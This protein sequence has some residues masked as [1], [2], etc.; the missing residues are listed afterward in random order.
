ME[1]EFW[2]RRDILY[3][4]LPILGTLMIV[5]I[6]LGIIFCTNMLWPM[7]IVGALVLLFLVCEMFFDQRA[8]SKVVFS[9]EGIEERFLGKKVDFI[10]WLEITEVKATYKGKSG[11]FLSFFSRDREIFM[12]NSKKMY[13][14][15]MI[16]CP[17]NSVKNQLKN[18]DRF[19][20]FHKDN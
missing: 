18:I 5:F 15:I 19:K 14:T 7:S 20:C 17:I 9:D 11:V 12:V 10:S 1:I 6:I 3:V 8:L 4:G 2:K 16:L 13:A